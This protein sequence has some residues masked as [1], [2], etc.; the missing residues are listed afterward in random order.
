MNMRINVGEVRHVKIE[1]FSIKKEEFNIDNA[2]YELI[3]KDTG[4]SEIEGVCGVEGHLI[5][6][7]IQPKFSGFYILKIV[8][9]IANERL[10]ENIEI[11]VKE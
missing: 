7:V 2:E 3:R 10:I 11:N 9:S 8:Y 1:V 5:D 4:K 6:V